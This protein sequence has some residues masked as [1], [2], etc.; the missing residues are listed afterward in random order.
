MLS[1]PTVFSLRHWNRDRMATFY[2]RI[3][4]HRGWA[5]SVKDDVKAKGKISTTRPMR[6]LQQV[7]GF[8]GVRSW[9]PTPC[10]VI[11]TS[12]NPSGGGRDDS[13]R[14][15][16]ALPNDATCSASTPCTPL[17]HL[18]TGFRRLRKSKTN[19]SIFRCNWANPVSSKLK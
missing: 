15:K 11:G 10:R 16:G 18:R 6:T 17:A 9:E 13:Q 7:Q 4:N 8:L 14:L 1:G 5:A 19:N 2:E 12:R 3:Q